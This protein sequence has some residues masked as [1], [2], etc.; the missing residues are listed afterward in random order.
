MVSLVTV[1]IAAISART[2]NDLQD[3]RTLA[4]REFLKRFGKECAAYGI[5]VSV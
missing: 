4:G 1:S 3:A 5:I 2:V